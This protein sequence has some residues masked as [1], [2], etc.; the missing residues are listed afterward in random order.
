MWP[1][2]VEFTSEA[3]EKAEK[4]MKKSAKSVRSVPA[5]AIINLVNDKKLCSVNQVIDCEH[6]SDLHKLFPIMPGRDSFKF[7]ILKCL[8]SVDLNNPRILMTHDKMVVAANIG[9]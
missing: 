5:E 9:A 4:E 8:R 7:D 3:E 6:F 2:I 1:S